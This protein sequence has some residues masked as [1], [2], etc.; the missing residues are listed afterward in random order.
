[1]AL[2]TRDRALLGDEVRDQVPAG[3]FHRDE[4]PET[5]QAARGSIGAA[6]NQLEAF[7]H[8][9]NDLVAEDILTAEQG[10]AL[11]AAAQEIS[12]F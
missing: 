7:T 11:I 8:Q 10:A 3:V 6:I 9:V 1:M 2:S 5:S 4:V 12:R